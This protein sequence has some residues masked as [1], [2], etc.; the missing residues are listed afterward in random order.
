MVEVRRGSSQDAGLEYISHPEQKQD[1]LPRSNFVL[2]RD[3]IAC[4]SSEDAE[5]MRWGKTLRWW[6][7][8]LLNYF[9]H[10]P[11]NAYTEGA[12]T[13]IKLLKRA[14]YGLTNIEVYMKKMLLGLLPPLLV[15]FYHTF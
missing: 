9:E 4:E 10:R 12:N 2:G 13:K 15:C 6:G 5:M 8:Y 3:L 14:S 7:K 11:T 1:L